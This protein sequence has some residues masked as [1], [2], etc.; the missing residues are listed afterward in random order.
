MDKTGY[1]SEKPPAAEPSVDEKVAAAKAKMDWAKKH[2]KKQPDWAKK[3]LED[4][5]NAL[6]EKKSA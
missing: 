1:V 6:I 5:R 3:V 4:A 2:K